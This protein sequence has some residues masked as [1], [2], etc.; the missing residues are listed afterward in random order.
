VKKTI[1][2]KKFVIKKIFIG[3]GLLL[4]VAVVFSAL[5]PEDYIIQRSIVIHAKP[6]I[7]YPYLANTKNADLWMPWGEMDSQIKTTY[8]GPDQ[9]VGSISSWD[10]PGQMGT[11]QAEVI[12]AVENE[13]VQTKITYSKPMQMTQ[14]SEFVLN[15]DGENTKM[16]WIV[17]G[18]SAF[19]MRFMCT[20]MLRDMDT[21]VGGMFERGL[22]KLKILVE[23]KTIQQ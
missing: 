3:I 20:V 5:K 4:T 15:P 19:I 16:S 8:S 14:E 9:G 18:K 22:S 6:E 21:F 23:E 12:A 13:S 7:I 1:K 10:S 11:G 17:S 2:G